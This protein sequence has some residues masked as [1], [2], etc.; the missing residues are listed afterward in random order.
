MIKKYFGF[1]LCLLFFS[2]LS[3]SDTLYL[4]DN[5]VKAQK[6]D[7]I[8]T[9]QSK[10][11]S[12]LYVYDKNSDIISIQEINVPAN[13]IPNNGFSW[14]NWVAEGAQGSTSRVL[15]NIDLKTAQIQNS[16]C[17]TQNGWIESPRQDNFF[18]TL[19]NLRLELIPIQN[20]RRLGTTGTPNPYDKRPVWQPKIIVDGQ[21]IPGVILDAW[22]ATW[23][24]D[25]SELSEKNIE[26]YLPQEN[27][28]YP[29]Y[30]P[31]WLQVNTVVG[32]AK[33]RII[34][35]GRGLQ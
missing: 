8:V 23:P 33:I 9:N 14:R 4:R 27:S 18:S 7:Y 20:R 24:K 12:L 5:L 3:A 19:L 15:Y 35:S 31:Y 26:A 25:G 29:S 21:A 1:I 28:N 32:N 6:G 10:T 17:L 30:F 13:R 34:D 22:K 2:N 11:Y 16:Y